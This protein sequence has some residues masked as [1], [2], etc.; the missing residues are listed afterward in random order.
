VSLDVVRAWVNQQ[1]DLVGTGKVLSLGAF[2]TE[3]DSPET[4][5]YVALVRQPS[6]PILGFAEASP[7][8]TVRTYLMVYAGTLLACEQAADA[9]TE[10]IR[11]LT[12]APVPVPA[13]DATM[14]VSD[15]V[16][17]PAEQPTDTDGEFAFL[18]SAD[19]VMI[20]ES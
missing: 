16:I 11:S 5:A 4:G 10:R 7:F 19:F 15:N 17:G 6:Q 20:S 12:G 9:L 13:A 3:I 18:I 1:D 14:L 8:T 2:L